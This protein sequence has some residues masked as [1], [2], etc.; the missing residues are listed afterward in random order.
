[1]DDLVR[2]SQQQVV[3][4][5]YERYSLRRV[6]PQASVRHVRDEAAL[7]EDLLQMVLPASRCAPQARK[8]FCVVSR[9]LTL[10]SDPAF[11]AATR[12]AV[13]R[14]PRHRPSHVR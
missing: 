8:T 13:L 7:R 9:S 11:L 14:T 3:Q 2:S 5:E 1:M 12:V 4:V 10:C 6:G